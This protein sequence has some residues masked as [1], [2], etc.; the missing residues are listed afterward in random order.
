LLHLYKKYDVPTY[1]TFPLNGAGLELPPI[2]V[3]VFIVSSTSFV[4]INE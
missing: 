1:S 3:L 4:P 2:I